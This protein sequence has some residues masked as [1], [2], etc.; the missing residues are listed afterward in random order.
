MFVGEIF[1][2]MQARNVN[3]FFFQFRQACNLCRTDQTSIYRREI[4]L[5]F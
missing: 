1:H 2:I 4:Q 3:I 5:E